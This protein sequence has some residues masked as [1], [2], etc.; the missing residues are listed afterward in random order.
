MHICI[1]QK[2]PDSHQVLQMPNNGQQTR[3]HP[4]RVDPARN[5]QG[6]GIAQL[7]A[8]TR[9]KSANNLSAPVQKY[10]HETNLLD[11]STK[12]SNVSSSNSDSSDQ[13]SDSDES[14]GVKDK[15]DGS[16]NAENGSL[17]ESAKGGGTK[18]LETKHGKEKLEAHPTG[19]RREVNLHETH[20]SSA[21]VELK[22]NTKAKHT[23][24][25]TKR[26]T[27]VGDSEE[28]ASSSENLSKAQKLKNHSPDNKHCSSDHKYAEKYGT[29]V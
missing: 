25:R 19:R 3:N 26:T 5:Q 14:E 13:N 21:K 18:E 6:N 8:T 29:P 12:K 11:T 1:I 15:I 28:K 2:F 10:I 17:L 20:V 22:T 27:E 7:E 16:T 9:E 24:S 4:P 23:E